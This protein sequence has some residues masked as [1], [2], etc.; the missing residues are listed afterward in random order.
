[1]AIDVVVHFFMSSGAAA[2]G[3]SLAVMVRLLLVGSSAMTMQK[4]PV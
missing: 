3:S 2:K 1:M 4:A